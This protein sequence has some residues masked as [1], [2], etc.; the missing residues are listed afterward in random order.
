MKI[1]DKLFYRYCNSNKIESV[2]ITK[3]GRKYIYAKVRPNTRLIKIVRENL[4]APVDRDSMLTREYYKTRSA[5]GKQIA[6]EIMINTIK[7]LMY[8]DSTV[9]RT[10]S[11]K[12]L[13]PLFKE[14]RKFLRRRKNI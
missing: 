4:I 14:V 3:I 2:T 8:N 9:L 11:T 10:A 13:I 12:D 5:V 6:K 1:G 7:S